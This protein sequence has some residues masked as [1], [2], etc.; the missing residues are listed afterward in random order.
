MCFFQ[1]D[2]LLVHFLF[3]G[4]LASLQSTGAQCIESQEQVQHQNAKSTKYRDQQREA[5]ALLHLFGCSTKKGKE[6]STRHYQANP[7]L[8]GNLEVPRVRPQK[9]AIKDLPIPRGMSLGAWRRG[10]GGA[11]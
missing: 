7:R 2:S 1:N 9:P 6:V 5:L 11:A 4:A 8:H 3:S 10:T